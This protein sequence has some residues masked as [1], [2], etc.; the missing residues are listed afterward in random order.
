MKKWLLM[1]LGFSGFLFAASDMH[2]DFLWKNLDGHSLA[3]KGGSL[4]LKQTCGTCH[5]VD[6]IEKHN[7]H[8]G[9]I[10]EPATNQEQ[11]CLACHGSGP[12]DLESETIQASLNTTNLIVKA[13]DSYSWNPEASHYKDKEGVPWYALTK[14]VSQNCGQCHSGIPNNKG[15]VGLPE[16]QS[17]EAALWLTGRLFSNQKIS[18]SSL[19]ISSKNKLN[20]SWDV[21]AKRGMHCSDCH[22][23]PNNPSFSQ[24]KKDSPAKLKFDARR[25][26]ISDY[27]YRPD[28]RLASAG[29]YIT[30]KPAA[31]ALDCSN[32]H[33]SN[34]TNYWDGLSQKH[35]EKVS[36]Q[37]CHIPKIYSPV[38]KSMDVTLLNEDAEP[39]VSYRNVDST[40]LITPFSPLLLRREITDYPDKRKNYGSAYFPFNIVTHTFWKDG[41][42]PIEKDVVQKAMSQIEGSEANR[43][44]VL[45]AL[46]KMGYANVKMAKELVPY[47]ISHN[48]VEGKKAI[49]ECKA[50][51]S[52][53]GILRQEFDLGEHELGSV[54]LKQAAG[55]LWESEI[56]NHP[57]KGNHLILKQ[58]N[59]VDKLYVFGKDRLPLVDWA[60]LILM[61]LV[62]MGVLTHGF[63]R[64]VTAKNR[65]QPGTEVAGKKYLYT[66]YERFWHWM[67]SMTVL[68]LFWSGLEIHLPGTFGILGFDKAN[69]LHHVMGIILAINAFLALF[70][71]VASGDIRQYLPKPQGFISDAILQAAYYVEGIFS[72]KAH[73]FHKHPG[74]KLNP[75][76][77]LTYLGLLNILLP[78]LVVTGAMMMFPNAL[79]WLVLWAGGLKTVAVIHSACSW[80]MVSFVIMHVY[81]ST[82]GKRP[83]HYIKG[84]VTGWE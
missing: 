55:V 70:Y 75:L 64:V 30:D 61:L 69:S 58:K 10:G 84:M 27:L 13:G 60:G 57:S 16:F 29:I 2:P 66:T 68:L 31:K 77:Q 50:C 38:I 1:I 39:L 44:L 46:K 19:N 17:K 82:T 53:N 37:A 80:L 49:R 5:D 51:H 25:G 36:C 18:K 32:C 43:D 65:I 73:P 78:L 41:N 54:E 81:L 26:A 48:A 67:Q 15:P 22:G 79:E 8:R 83:T 71:H 6:Y 24:I 14:P 52:K 12:L 56:M 62:I 11:N 42:T 33:E 21:H 35:F 34:H 9:E 72:G 4:S 76:Q 45:K 3:K 7:S 28:H 40:G 63:F 20:N 59:S 47:P 23:S 74:K